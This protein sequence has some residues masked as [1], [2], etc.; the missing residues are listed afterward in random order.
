M[1]KLLLA[2]TAAMALAGPTLANPKDHTIVLSNWKACA[3]GPLSE[4]GGQADWA[5]VP[6]WTK[7]PAIRPW[8]DNDP[9]VLALHGLCSAK[10]HRVVLCLPGWDMDGPRKD[11]VYLICSGVLGG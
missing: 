2:A 4:T 7:D 3:I 6:A 11:N 5:A 1:K 8:F 9:R 10:F